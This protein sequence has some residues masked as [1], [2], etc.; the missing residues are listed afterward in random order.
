MS[1]PERRTSS[2]ETFEKKARASS[3]SLCPIVGGFATNSASLAS[4]K[5]LCRSCKNES[6]AWV[7]EVGV[8]KRLV[9]VSRPMLR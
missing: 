3:K 9:G 5:A 2:S 8:L 4:D 6:T 1:A 7:S